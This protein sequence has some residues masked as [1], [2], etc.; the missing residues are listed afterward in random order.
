MDKGAWQ[1]TVHG[2][3]KSRTRLNDLAR[4]WCLLCGSSAFCQFGNGTEAYSRV[5]GVSREMTESR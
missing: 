2:V 1:A 5:G 3:T 4:G